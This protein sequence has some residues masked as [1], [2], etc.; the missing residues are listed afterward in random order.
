MDCLIAVLGEDSVLLD[1]LEQSEVDQ[2]FN[3]ESC[4]E[5]TNVT[6]V[7]PVIRLPIKDRRLPESIVDFYKKKL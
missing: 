6:E 4:Q 1:S 5:E 7:Q 2:K 3:F